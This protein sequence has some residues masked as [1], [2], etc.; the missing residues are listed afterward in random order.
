MRRQRY[1]LWVAASYILPSLPLATHSLMSTADLVHWAVPAGAFYLAGIWS[2]ARGMAGKC[3][4]SAHPR[5]AAVVFI[6]TLALLF[7]Y[8]QITDQLWM[9]MLVLNTGIFILLLLPVYSVLRRSE[10]PILL[11]DV[12]RISYAL[13]V[14]YSFV[15]LVSVAVLLPVEIGWE[16]TQSGYW[17]LM[18]GI[19]LVIT[20]WFTFVLLACVIRELYQTLKIERNQ[21]PLTRLL[22]RRAFFEQAERLLLLPNSDAWALIVSDVDHFKRVNDTRGHAAGDQALSMVG[23]VLMQ[24]ARQNDLVA[25]F[26]GE[27]FVVLLRCKDII[28][29]KTV[30][31]RMRLQIAGTHFPAL[32]GHLTASFGV[33]LITPGKTIEYAIEQADAMLY[34]AKRTGRNQV[35]H[36]MAA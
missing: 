6:L 35:V 33:A 2:A 3:D 5:I 10:P 16:V 27:E 36:D 8:S 32:E 13:L 22:N 26:G 23:Q 30:A 12:L 7:Y 11:E 18:L 19:N 34:H 9:R 17:F 14:V 29:A 4:G 1:L 28:A 24:Q 15:R 31:E 25:R 20:L 21:D